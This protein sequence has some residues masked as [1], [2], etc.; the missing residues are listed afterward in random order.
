[1]PLADEESHLLDWFQLSSNTAMGPTFAELFEEVSHFID[2][3]GLQLNPSDS[4]LPFIRDMVTNQDDLIDSDF[5]SLNSN[6]AVVHMLAER[7]ELTCWSVLA[8]NKLS[9]C[10][11][12]S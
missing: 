3:A 12:H 6:E 9:C 10:A 8:C 2:I 11:N 7:P 4:V 1:M 5:I